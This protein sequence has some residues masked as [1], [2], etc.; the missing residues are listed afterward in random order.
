[1]S[2]FS[3][4]TKHNKTYKETLGALEALIN[5]TVPSGIST[6]SQN[7]F[8]DS[9]HAQR[10]RVVPPQNPHK[11]FYNL[12]AMNSYVNVLKL[13]HQ[14]LSYIHMA[15][16]K[17]KGSTCAFCE[18]ILRNEGYKTGLF[19]SPH[20]IDVRERIRIDGIPVPKAVFV[21]TVWDIF[22]GLKQSELFPSM[23]TYFRFITL[24][25]LKCFLDAKVDVAIMECGLG[26][27]LDATNI[28]R[29]DVCGISS[30]GYDHCSVL[31]KTLDKIAFE[32]AGIMKKNVPVVVQPQ[33]S[34][35]IMPVFEEH[36]KKVGAPLYVSP[37]FDKWESANNL[38]SITLGL[39]GTHQRM[40]ASLALSLT[41]IWKLS[42]DI[43]KSTG[44]K[45]ISSS[46]SPIT[47]ESTTSD[48]GGLSEI[49]P[50]KLTSNTLQGL[51]ECKLGGRSQH[52]EFPIHKLHFY[53]DGAHT[54]ESLTYAFQWF[55]KAA[56]KRGAEEDSWIQ[57]LS[58]DEE[59][60]EINHLAPMLH[61]RGEETLSDG[62]NLEERPLRYLVFNYTGGRDANQLLE[63]FI[64]KREFFDRVFFVPTDSSHFSFSKVHELSDSDR[65]Q[66][67]NL[68]Q[69]WAD[70]SSS[71]IFT[72][73]NTLLEDLFSPNNSSEYHRER[74]IFVTG[75]MYLV[76]DF[77]RKLSALKQ[78]RTQKE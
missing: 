55:Q 15:G 49:Q 56:E 78:S 59:L 62:D 60:E 57:D 5:H 36:S 68:Q 21:D 44:G 32:K 58:S 42:Q 10:T 77:L 29:P 54:K 6:L 71:K 72:R 28:I 8:A 3:Q 51:T 64:K 26:G 50:H 19:T 14:K 45:D 33:S 74:H 47:I 4:S 61:G 30:I 25:A 53:L 20:L 70:N 52:I 75:S 37:T 69:V 2:T 39:H 7:G 40:N 22:D 38:H 17:G 12:K 1:M 43:K 31:G 18:S 23:T 16:T 46:S 67:E 35:E 66:L 73:I 76:G 13:P 65:E 41:D 11:Q 9:S 48:S 63:P 34:E 27:R 24:V